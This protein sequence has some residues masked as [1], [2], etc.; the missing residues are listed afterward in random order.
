LFAQQLVLKPALP[1]RTR[2]ASTEE[3]RSFYLESL[4]YIQKAVNRILTAIAPENSVVRQ[5]H[6]TSF[7]RRN[8]ISSV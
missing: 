1:H 7:A 2:L 8:L 3:T 5:K 4:Q 6:A